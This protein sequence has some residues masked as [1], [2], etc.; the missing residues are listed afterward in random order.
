VQINNITGLNNGVTMT[1]PVSRFFLDGVMSVGE[2]SQPNPD[3]LAAIPCVDKALYSGAG[4][5]FLN[6]NFGSRSTFS[7][8]A[9]A[10]YGNLYYFEDG[11]TDP[12]VS[13]HFSR[14]IT[15]FASPVNFVLGHRYLIAGACEDFWQENEFASIVF[16]ADQG[17]AGVPAPWTSYTPDIYALGDPC[18]N[19]AGSLLTS[20]DYL[21]TLV[22][23]SG[24]KVVPYRGSRLSAQNNIFYVTGPSPTNQDTIFVENQNTVLGS[25]SSSNANYPALYTHVNIT[26]VVHFT[27][28][29]ASPNNASNAG[30]FRICPRTVADIVTTV[31]VGD[32]APL[33]LA[34][35][36]YPN[37]ARTVNLSF[38]VPKSSN[39]DLAVYDLLGRKVVQLAKGFYPAGSFQKAW[40]GATA[41]G[42]RVGTGMYF[43]RLRVGDEVRTA[44]TL[45]LGN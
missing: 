2:M 28:N 10:Q 22:S 4:G 9:T 36:A 25:N 14:G 3:T 23:L 21:S 45:L 29:P 43:Y 44:R 26:G 19:P 42:G 6:G 15:V 5:E 37:P 18:D 8:I 38:T 32:Q 31:G 11:T 33:A 35:S 41:S 34:L 13:Q 16:V 17:T 12:A 39:I 7:G 24:M 30:T 1:T 27:N 20:R 40:N